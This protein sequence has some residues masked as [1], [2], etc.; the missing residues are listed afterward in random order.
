MGDP[1]RVGATP[2]DIDK[3][4]D[5]DWTETHK[6]VERL[7]ARIAKAAREER[8]GKVK[9]LQRILVR[10]LPARRLA[11][12]RVTSNKGKN[13]PGI[14]KVRW[15]SS[16]RK[17]QAVN[18]LRKRRGYK[19]LP[20]RRVYIPKRNGKKRAL[21]IPSMHDRAMQALHLLALE[22]VAEQRADPNSYGFRKARS[23]QDAHGRCQMVLSHRNSAAWILDADIKACFDEISHEWMLRHIPMDKGILYKWLKAGYVEGDVF[24]DTEQGTPQ[25]GPISPTLANMTLDGL[26]AHV[27]AAA[28]RP[29]WPE[30][31]NKVHIVRYADDLVV[32]AANREILET[33]VVPAIVAFLGERGLKLSE[34]KTKIVHIDEGF[35]FLGVNIRKYDG[36][37]RRRPTK[38]KIRELTRKTRDLMRRNR[39]SA[40]S[41]MLR[42]LNM[43]LKGWAHQFR[44]VAASKAFR[45]IDDCVYRQLWS[46]ARKRHKNKGARW[47]KKRYFTTVGNNRWVFHARQPGQN[48]PIVLFRT[49]SLGIR[50]HIKVRS[51][52]KYYDARY[53]DYFKERWKHRRRYGHQDNCRW[54]GHQLKLPLQAPLFEPPGRSQTGL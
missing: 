1:E 23:I 50:R 17:T 24:H 2:D 36:K 13:T 41:G 28:P 8:W 52:A 31:S 26:E 47:V 5:I 29:R 43:V 15:G 9:S 34:E 32:T 39:G 20:L 53:T 30:P 42:Q 16:R 49:S 25:G 14:D 48:G 35:D 37:F 3:W 12:R 10:S 38:A 11:V 4:S 54:A 44:H 27:A 21:G 40:T 45:H 6:V 19:P 51:E 7:Q 18:A 33:Q 22:P 46:W